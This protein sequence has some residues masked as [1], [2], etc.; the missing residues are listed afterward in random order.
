MNCLADES[1]DRQIVERLRQ[2][3]HQVMKVIL[4]GIAL[5]LFWKIF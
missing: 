2:D 4:R 1:V 3:G 5:C